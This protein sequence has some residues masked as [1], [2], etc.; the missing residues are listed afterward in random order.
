MSQTDASS[1]RPSLRLP[2][3]AKQERP[4]I[5]PLS[6]AQK[7]WAHID[8]VALQE[9]WLPVLWRLE[10][11]LHVPAFIRS[12]KSLIARHEILRTRFLPHGDGF[13]QE[14]M[15]E[16]KI[17]LDA[18]DVT[19]APKD[20]REFEIWERLRPICIEQTPLDQG[21][22]R[23]ELFK[24]ADDNYILGGFIHHIAVD[25]VGFAKFL[26]ELMEGYYNQLLGR[27]MPDAPK[28]QYADYAL[29]EK[30]WLT[31]EQKA[32]ADAYWEQALAHAEPLTLP[33]GR[34][35]GELPSP[36]NVEPFMLPTPLGEAARTFASRQ[37]VTLNILFMCV[38]SILISRWSGQ[39]GTLLGTFC[40]GRPAGFEAV[41]GCF[42]Q[43]RPFFLNLEDDPTVVDL[44]LRARQA[45]AA[46]ADIRK[47]APLDLLG[48][49]NIGNVLV[50]YT[51]SSPADLTKQGVHR[52][53][54][55]SADSSAVD[56]Y[57][58]ALVENV[59]PASRSYLRGNEVGAAAMEASPTA[60]SARPANKSAALRTST[61]L[62][63][64][65]RPVVP[66]PKEADIQ[67]ARSPKILGVAASITR[68]PK[69]LHTEFSR[70]LHFAVTQT[71]NA[72]RGRITY[73]SDRF[74][75][76]RIKTLAADLVGLTEAIIRSPNC[77]VSE[78]A[79][80]IGH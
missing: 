50:N 33:G 77:R 2:A 12:Y 75:A 3:V 24:V 11:Q 15:P 70:D 59:R 69:W 20:L 39:T 10:G 32:A 34:M 52:N 9:Q 19:D 61:S 17:K 80:H 73:A 49:L 72:L 55:S 29:W 45:A 22:V 6:A 53:A 64:T 40:R 28:L 23:L 74:S 43:M 71:P 35:Q 16:D 54:A 78:L 57:A 56:H 44:L 31:D 7:L 27:P 4:E 25:G 26:R 47:P 65:G 18:F 66:P 51:A 42:T 63:R 67:P 14:V 60:P 46:A 62:V 48:R 79:P 5:L 37:A 13:R 36:R 21:A 68:L 41:M 8:K 30:R 58:S 76:E 1:S 38:V